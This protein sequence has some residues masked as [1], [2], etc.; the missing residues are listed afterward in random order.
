MPGANSFLAEATKKYYQQYVIRAKDANKL[1]VMMPMYIVVTEKFGKL[2]YATD[3][4]ADARAWARKAFGVK[5]KQDVRRER[6]VKPCEKC[7]CAPC[8]CG[9]RQ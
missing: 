8:T 9:P 3:S 6:I 7:D 2:Q 5:R 1:E 4:I